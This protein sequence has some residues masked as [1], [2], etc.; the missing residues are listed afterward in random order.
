MN[1]V[2]TC[3]CFIGKNVLLLVSLMTL[4]AKF[5]V[6]EGLTV[7]FMIVINWGFSA[8]I[9]CHNPRGSLFVY[10]ILRLL[11]KFLCINDF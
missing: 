9:A 3:A 10:H 2:Y 5:L 6:I 8:P 1:E 4:R 7:I 11:C